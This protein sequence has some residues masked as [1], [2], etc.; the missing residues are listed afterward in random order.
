M[1]LAGK[2]ADWAAAKEINDVESPGTVNEYVAQNWFTHSKEGD[3]NLNDNSK[4][5]RQLRKMRT[6][7]K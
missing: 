3:V 5:R 2:K 4:L 6:C 7:L 1:L